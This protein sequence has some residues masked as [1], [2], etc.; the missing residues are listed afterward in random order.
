MDGKALRLHHGTRMLFPAAVAYVASQTVLLTAFKGYLSF[1]A[2]IFIILAVIIVVIKNETA[3]QYFSQPMFICM[4]VVI[5]MFVMMTLDPAETTYDIYKVVALLFASVLFSNRNYLPVIESFADG[6]LAATGAIVAL[7][8]LGLI[9]TEQF[10]VVDSWTKEA[11]GFINPNNA[12]YFI[13]VSSLIYFLSGNIKRAWIALACLA[14]FFTVGVYSRSYVVMSS[15]VFAMGAAVIYFPKWQ[16]VISFS[17]Y[18]VS[19]LAILIGSWFYF[20]ILAYPEELSYYQGTW[21]DIIT[22]GRIAVAL[23]YAIYRSNSFIGYSIFKLDSLYVELIYSTGPVFMSI[24]LFKY[25][26]RMFRPFF[27]PYENRMQFAT[28]AVLVVGLFEVQLFNLT[29]LGAMIFYMGIGRSFSGAWNASDRGRRGS[30]PAHQNV[31]LM[32]TAKQ[33]P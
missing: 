6:T 3:T 30:P 11:G 16:R 28:A 7:A 10:S 23:E 33:F 4:S 14:G 8:T 24:L 1:L 32:P 19:I 27:D 22:S 21:V 9:P 25:A 15:I 5:I 20:G 26:G 29:P 31:G 12:P 13:F 2:M 17:V 18:S